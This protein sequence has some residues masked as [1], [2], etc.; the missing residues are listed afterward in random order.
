[1][2]LKYGSTASKALIC[3]LYQGI[4]FRIKLFA[5]L[6]TLIA[7][8]P[9]ILSIGK[10]K[11]FANVHM[12]SAIVLVLLE[13][14]VVELIPNA[15]YVTVVSVLCHIGRIFAMLFLIASEGQSSIN[16]TCLWAA[17]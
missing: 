4:Y 3:C 17:A 11:Y 6:F 8:A 15:Y 13:L 1:M 10:T 16:G 9:V 14:A 5:N 12:Y 7:Y 2:N